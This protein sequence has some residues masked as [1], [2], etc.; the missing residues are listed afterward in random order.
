[1]R[2]C[3][4]A[5]GLFRKIPQEKGRAR[6]IEKNKPLLENFEDINKQLQARLDQHGISKGGDIG[7]NHNTSHHIVGPHLTSSTALNP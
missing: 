6:L 2:I 5:P 7:Q 1:M 4:H 3:A